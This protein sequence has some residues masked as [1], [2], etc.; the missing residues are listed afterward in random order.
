MFWNHSV[1]LHFSATLY[2]KY[3]Y[4]YYYCCCCCCFRKPVEEIRPVAGSRFPD[5][6]QVRESFAKEE[7]VVRLLTELSEDDRSTLGY[8]QDELILD[9]QYSGYHCDMTRYLHLLWNITFLLMTSWLNKPFNLPYFRLPYTLKCI[10]T[11]ICKVSPLYSL[12]FVFPNNE[13]K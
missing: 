6:V 4:Y 8:Q 7:Q 3:Y 12:L 1:H 5:R 10:L 9:C 2:L 13:P 11:S